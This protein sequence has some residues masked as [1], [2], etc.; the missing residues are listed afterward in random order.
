M[1]VESV[2]A[3]S[4]STPMELSDGEWFCELIIRSENGT[5][6]LQMLADSPERFAIE[7]PESPHETE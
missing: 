7:P 3:I 5:V 1:D 6:A 2:V 4:L